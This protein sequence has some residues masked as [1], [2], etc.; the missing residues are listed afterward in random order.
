MRHST[1][2]NAIPFAVVLA[3]LAPGCAAQ[4]PAASVDSALA[5]A[6]AALGW[7]ALLAAGATVEVHARTHLMGA[8]A[9][10]RISFDARGRTLSIVEGP[11]P[12]RAGFDGA[13]YWERDWTDTAREL[14]LGDASRAELEDLVLT[15]RWCVAGERLR[16][17]LAPEGVSDEFALQFH[18]ADGVQHGTL[19]LDSST[20]RP[21]SVRYGTDGAETHWT[22][23]DWRVQDGF[24]FPWRSESSEQGLQ[25]RRVASSVKV[26]RAL[27]AGAFTAQLTPAHDTRFDA[28]IAAQLEV[29]KVRSGHM[30]VHP[31]IDG[32][33]LGWFIFDSGAGTSCIAKSATE[34]L[35]GPFGEILARGIGGQ[36][37]THF[38]RAGEMKIGPLSVANPSFMELDLAFLEPHFGVPVGGILGY[39]LF[40]RCVAEV[41][42]AGGAI[43]LHDPASYE[44]PSGGAWESALLFGR[45]PCV[46][47]RAEDREGVYLIDTG[48]ADDTVTLHYQQVLDGEWLEGRET[49]D[50]KAGGVGGFVATRVGKLASFRL[51][52]RDFPDL[53]ASFAL[54]DKGAFANDY[55]DG[56]IGGKLLEPFRLVFDYP[57]RRLGFVERER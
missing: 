30:L 6:R 3:L 57:H 43:S 50:G 17:E 49:S 13:V 48:A 41:D 18:H 8:E 1:R 51:G 21:R 31:L 47:A 25:R 10:E 5:R 26:G 32:R 52:G 12:M 35:Q 38:W 9:N 2:T 42:M 46:R 55:I 56:N 16:F 34:G 33:D 44:L 14:V 19:V 28:S 27:D 23:S 53:P 20:M 29:K 54:E 37:P 40:M 39:E 15:G 7:D 4:E 11:M 36:V 24:A 45:Q 22:F